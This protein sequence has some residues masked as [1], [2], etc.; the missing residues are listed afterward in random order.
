MVKKSLFMY[1]TSIQWYK[2]ARNVFALHT[3]KNYRTYIHIID[4]KVTFFMYLYTSVSI[5]YDYA[6]SIMYKCLTSAV[7]MSVYAL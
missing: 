6:N 1:N 2:H 3:N 5:I 7:I 4:V